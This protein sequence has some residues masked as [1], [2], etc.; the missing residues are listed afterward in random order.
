MPASIVSEMVSERSSLQSL[1]SKTQ[2]V[3]QGIN[4]STLAFSNS[5]RPA[6][7][8][9]TFGCEQQLHTQFFVFSASTSYLY[10]CLWHLPHYCVIHCCYG[11]LLLLHFCPIHKSLFVRYFLSREC[12]KSKPCDSSYQ[13]RIFPQRQSMQKARFGKE[14]RQAYPIGCYMRIGPQHY[15]RTIGELSTCNPRPQYSTMP[16]DA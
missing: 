3:S 10:V 1:G 7:A 9:W 16:A 15:R 2:Q 4:R 11:G 13:V 5:E 8:G 6:K 12:S 14:R